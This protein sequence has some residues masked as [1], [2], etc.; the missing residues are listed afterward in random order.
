MTSKIIIIILS[1]ALVVVCAKL[2]IATNVGSQD[3]GKETSADESSSVDAVYDNIMSR[4]S[5]RSFKTTPVED[6]KMEKLLRAGMAAPSAMDKRPWHF[7]VVREKA[8]LQKIA[9][10]TPNARMAA[11]APLAIVV[12]G[13]LSKEKDDWTKDYWIQD[14]SAATQ[15][16]LLAAHAMGLGAVWTGT[17]PSAERVSLVAELFDT[18]EHIIPFCTIVIGYPEGDVTPKDKW[19]D[20]NVSYEM[21]GE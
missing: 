2:Y 15:N 17:Y 20:M 14:V 7:I 5:V 13:D 8:T 12:C 1:I 10:I 19:D 9:E 16:I 6:D 4:A 18:P 3:A 21:Y 11:G